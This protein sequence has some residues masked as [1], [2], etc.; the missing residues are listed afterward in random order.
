MSLTQV[1]HKINAT[2]NR[3]PCIGTRPCSVFISYASAEAATAA[4]LAVFLEAAGCAPWW[5]QHL[6]AGEHFRDAIIE[7][8]DAADAAV[9]VWSAASIRS[10]WVEAE[11]TRAAE[12]GKL[13]PVRFADLDPKAIPPPFGTFHT[14]LLDDRAGMMHAIKR[15]AAAQP[16][17]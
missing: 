11:A 2:L 10:R 16:I 4:E 7:A 14:L 6:R 12:Q 15:L 8:L 17:G 9:V 13:V 3:Q 5:S 1:M